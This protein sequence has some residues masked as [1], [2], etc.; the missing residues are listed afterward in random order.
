[1]QD[2]FICNYLSYKRDFCKFYGNWG[3]NILEKC[4]KCEN[5]KCD[6]CSNKDSSIYIDNEFKPCCD[7]C[8]LND[9]G[10]IK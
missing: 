9:R 5:K 10:E 6:K 2:Y 1:M 4:N 3:N 8:I 7:L